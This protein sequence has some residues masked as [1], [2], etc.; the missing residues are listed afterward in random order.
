MRKLFALLALFLTS[1]ILANN[2]GAAEIPAVVEGKIINVEPSKSITI[3]ITKS[4]S[5]EL[6]LADIRT[7]AVKDPKELTDN[8]GTAAGVGSAGGAVGA[9]T[10]V[11]NPPEGLQQSK[12]KDIALVSASVAV[13]SALVM[14][15]HNFLTQKP[16]MTI[17]DVNNAG[18]SDLTSINNLP[19]GTKVR[20]TQKNHINSNMP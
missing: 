18:L 17:Y 16:S 12:L 14:V 19:V 10:G 7:L 5:I 20:I 11:I 9:S 4:K 3:A 6:S 13:L 15:A 2:L 1:C 8:V